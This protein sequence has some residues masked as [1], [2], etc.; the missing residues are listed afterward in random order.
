MADPT[1]Y[2]GT[3]R[4][5]RVAGI[6]AVVFVVLFAF[7]HLAGHGGHGPMDH[8]RALSQPASA[9]DHGTPTP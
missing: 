6:A 2:P 5:V 3:P 7:L 1:Q 4:W 9:T 8:F